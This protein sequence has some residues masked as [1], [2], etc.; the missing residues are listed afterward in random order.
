[1]TNYEK[2]K[3]M[4][5]DEMA[6]TLQQFCPYYKEVDLECCGEEIPCALC[7]KKWLEKE[8]EDLDDFRFV[9]KWKYWGG[10][11]GNHDFRLTDA[12]CTHC[13]YRHPTIRHKRNADKLLPDRCPRCGAKMVGHITT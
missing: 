5:V 11:C 12:T 7:R 1:M 3:N 2:I 10:W 8:V 4:T 13:G 6:V 9:A